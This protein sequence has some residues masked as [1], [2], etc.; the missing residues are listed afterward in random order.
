MRSGTSLV[1]TVECAPAAALSRLASRVDTARAGDELVTVAN[2]LRSRALPSRSRGT[3]WRSEQ[4]TMTQREDSGLID[5]NA[6]LKEVGWS[7]PPPNESPQRQEGAC[8][9]LAT[10]P[11]DLHLLTMRLSTA[12]SDRAATAE[13]QSVA[14]SLPPRREGRTCLA[15]AVA[16]AA[17]L[18]VGGAAIG[19]TQGGAATTAANT[20]APPA[21]P[22]P[23]PLVHARAAA[24][25]VALAQPLPLDRAAMRERKP[26]AP[27]A[28]ASFAPPAPATGT[29]PPRAVVSK[30]NDDELV[31]PAL[32][33]PSETPAAKTTEVAP[34]PIAAAAAPVPAPPSTEATAPPEPS[35][36]AAQPR[37][38][39]PMTLE[40]AMRSA[41]MGKRVQ[42]PSSRQEVARESEQN[43]TAGEPQ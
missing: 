30:T 19:L 9:P 31:K 2:V 17:V 5:L 11:A 28:I 38:E 18:A 27:R 13:R 3:S 25:A 8:D 34:D 22:P 33:A 43:A 32:N 4:P 20:S 23:P 29:S 42:P 36:P 15:I 16:L 21:P 24:P 1:T 26:A 10:V 40:E 35:A 7:A 6:L 12:D 14:S 41:V 39:E 37:P